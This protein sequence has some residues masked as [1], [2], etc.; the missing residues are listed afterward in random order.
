VIIKDQVGNLLTKATER[1]PT[2]AVI[3]RSVVSRKPILRM[4][5]D[6]GIVPNNPRWPLVI[7]RGAISFPKSVDQ[8]S[9][10][11]ALFEKNGWGKSWRNSV[12]DFVHYH[13][14]F[15]RFWALRRGMVVSNSAESR[16]VSWI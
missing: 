10:I 8:A 5:A 2:D 12:Y 4:F 15:T 14:Q 1:R 7:Y 3:L 6:D 16:A 9:L 11:D 13:S